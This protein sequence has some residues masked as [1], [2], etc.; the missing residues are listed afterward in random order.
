M[1]RK[2][3][4]I[5]GMQFDRLK[6][7]KFVERDRFGNPMW[8]CECKCGNTVVVRVPSLLNGST[9]SCGCYRDEKRARQAGTLL[10]MDGESRPLA[11]WAR[12]KGISYGALMKRIERGETPVDAIDYLVKKAVKKRDV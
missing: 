10:T 9:T 3:T 1:G 7:V 8:L 2:I 5:T 11:Q 4:D 12:I 6:A